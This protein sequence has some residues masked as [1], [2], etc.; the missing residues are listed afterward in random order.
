MTD[1]SYDVVIV[2]GGPAGATTGRVL[3]ANG[4]PSLIIDKARFPR[5]KLC[6]G[7]LTIKT[8]NLVQQVFGVSID[9][10][11]HHSIFDNICEKYELNVGFEKT[12]ISDK[13]AIPFYLSER[14]VYDTF[15]LHKTRDA[16]VAVLEG[17][18]IKKVD[19]DNGL[20]FTGSGRTFKAKFI[21][22]A[23]GYNSVMRQIGRAHV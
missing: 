12:L 13:A 8:L 14:D 16:G 2:G 9:E 6:G 5:P 18:G 17:D 22:G 15:L 7:L 4:I 19:P 23:D 21:I 20:V 1:A 11:K 3:A 10:L